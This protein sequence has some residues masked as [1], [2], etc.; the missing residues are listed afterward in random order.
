MHRRG[1]CSFEKLNFFLKTGLSTRKIWQKVSRSL[2]IGNKILAVGL[3]LIS[4]CAC[5]KLLKT[6]FKKVQVTSLFENA[7]CKTEWFLTAPC[8]YFGGSTLTIFP[9]AGICSR[10]DYVK[11]KYFRP[12]TGSSRLKAAGIARDKAKNLFSSG[13]EARRPTPTKAYSCE[14]IVKQLNETA[15]K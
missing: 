5:Q 14:R 7:N 10:C 6:I 8:S 1:S 12:F 3:I 4:C 13:D 15:V 11:Y 9:Q 2:H